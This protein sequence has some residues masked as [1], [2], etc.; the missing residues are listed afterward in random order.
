M[1]YS[2]PTILIE[3]TNLLRIKSLNIKFSKYQKQLHQIQLSRG[4]LRKRF[5]E[6]IQQIYRGTPMP[7]C[8]FNKYVCNFIEIT[9]QH[10][11]SPANLL[12]IFRT[13]FP[14][15]SSGRLDL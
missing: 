8:D 1:K 14:K 10:G 13:H 4:V 2:L 5:S 11:I 3:G 12:H 9:L 7:K 6:N 15:N